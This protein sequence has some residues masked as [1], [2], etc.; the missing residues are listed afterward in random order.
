LGEGQGEG[1]FP[2]FW[3]LSGTV[4]SPPSA[5]AETYG[6][7]MKGLRFGLPS[8]CAFTGRTRSLASWA[9]ALLAVSS[10]FPA[11]GIAAE[12]MGPPLPERWPGKE[13]EAGRADCLK[14][15]SGLPVRFEMLGPIK[16]GVCGSPAPVR[17]KGFGKGAG[18]S[19]AIEPAPVVSCRLAEA[20]YRWTA[21]VVQPEAKKH[22]QTGIAGM[23]N[24]ASYDCRSHY[25]DPNLRL[26][27]H[28]H[29]NAV[30]IAEF[31][32]EKG[33]RIA[34]LDR[35]AGGD[36]RGAFL[37]ALHAGACKLFG[38]ALGPEANDAH[39]NHFHFDMKQRRQPLCDFSPEQLKAKAKAKEEAKK[40]A[41][42]SAAPAASPAGKAPAPALR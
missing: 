23:T 33:E 20:L 40:K 18:P 36:E 29:V 41:P 2:P 10:F 38:T 3:A 39:K 12:V 32:T 28:A 19:V 5:K 4:F 42:A 27:Q 34:I 7:C 21:D 22:L 16:D 14:R 17:L 9:L 37:H 31:I 15:L 30:D 24:V 35:W 11:A 8:I 26:S 13:V 1:R 25:G 6:E